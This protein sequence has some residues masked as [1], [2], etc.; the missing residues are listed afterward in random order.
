LVKNLQR[1]FFEKTRAFGVC[2][3]ELGG[4]IPCVIYKQKRKNLP[5]ALDKEEQEVVISKNLRF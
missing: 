3:C 1:N 5:K 4:V 2:E